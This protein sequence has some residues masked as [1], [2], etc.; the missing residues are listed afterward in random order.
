MNKIEKFENV[1]NEN[2]NAM[3]QIIVLYNM[4]CH[5]NY[6][7]LTEREKERLLGIIY[8]TYLKDET[9]TDLAKFS[10]IVINNYK[11]IIE[12]AILCNFQGVQKIIYDNI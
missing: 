6:T 10:D 11:K 9:S 2:K 7:S 1:I 8:S 5:E 3:L 12:E 4:S